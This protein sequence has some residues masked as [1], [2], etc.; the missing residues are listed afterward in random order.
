V[1]ITDFHGTDRRTRAFREIT[2]LEGN[3]VT[4]AK[5]D[6]RG[7]WIVTAAGGVVKVYQNGE[8]EE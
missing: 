2:V 3:A 4:A 1:K 5:Y 8:W 6:A 7:K